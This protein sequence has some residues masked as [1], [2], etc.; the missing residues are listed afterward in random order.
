MLI[1][2]SHLRMGFPSCLCP[3]GFPTK[4]LYT[5]QLFLIHATFRAHLILL[6]L[7]TRIIFG[8]QYISLSY[9]LC[10]FPHSPVTSSLLG[11][12]ILLSTLFSDTP[13]LHFSLDVSDHI[14]YPHKAA[15]NIRVLH[16]LIFLFLDSK[17]E[18][19]RSCTE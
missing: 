19:N 9:S 14:S 12:N 15:G 18:D 2:S 10:S 17:M 4:T 3:S 13:S 8:E 5:P 1:L 7:I 6:Y 16:I 11:P